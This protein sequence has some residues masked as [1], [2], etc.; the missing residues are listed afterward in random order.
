MHVTFRTSSSSSPFS[1]A[2]P[3]SS[4]NIFVTIFTFLRHFALH[5]HLHL[6][7]SRLAYTSYSHI[8]LDTEHPSPSTLTPACLLVCCS[9]YLY[10]VR[11]FDPPSTPPTLCI[12]MSCRPGTASCAKSLRV[13]RV[14]AAQRTYVPYGELPI[15]SVCVGRLDA[16]C[17]FTSPGK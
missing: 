16:T 9:F 5:L 1:F 11:L 2:S 13:W 6:H 12:C 7:S 3:S 14:C 4:I 10:R 15:L 17:T 8:P